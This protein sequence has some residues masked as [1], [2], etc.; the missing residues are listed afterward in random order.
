[1]FRSEKCATGNSLGKPRGIG[2]F[3]TVTAVT[4]RG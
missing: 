1:V 2:G 4:G 3:V